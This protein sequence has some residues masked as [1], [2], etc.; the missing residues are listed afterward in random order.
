MSL[1]SN[2]CDHQRQN[3][4]SCRCVPHA[5]HPKYARSED[6]PLFRRSNLK[7]VTAAHQPVL[8]EPNPSWLFVAHNLLKGFC[9]NI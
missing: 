7:K 2:S 9:Q 6:K 3:S 8:R 5:G 1:T 4:E